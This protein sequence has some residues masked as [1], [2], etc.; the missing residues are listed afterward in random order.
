MYPKAEACT[1]DSGGHIASRPA[2]ADSRN[3][4]P[5]LASRNSAA[6]RIL[7]LAVFNTGSAQLDSLRRLSLTDAEFEMFSKRLI[8][9]VEKATGG[10]PRA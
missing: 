8:A 1:G 3:R 4:D 7:K 2:L 9:Q 10:R 5:G 6:A